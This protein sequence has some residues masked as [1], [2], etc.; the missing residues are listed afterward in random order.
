MT[1]QLGVGTEAER[2]EKIST[3]NATRAKS[4]LPFPP[5]AGGILLLLAI[6]TLHEGRVHAELLGEVLLD[7]SVLSVDLIKCR[8]EIFTPHG[9]EGGEA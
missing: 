1:P 2:C 5:A 3:V 4:F 6:Q 7:A 9:V 8:F